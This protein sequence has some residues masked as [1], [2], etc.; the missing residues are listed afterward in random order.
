MKASQ[1]Y[2]GIPGAYLHFQSGARGIAVYPVQK[3]GT[4]SYVL[5]NTG[6]LA[7][8]KGARINGVGVP[9]FLTNSGFVLAEPGDENAA[10][11]ADMLDIREGLRQAES[12][13]SKKAAELQ[14]KLGGQVCTYVPFD[15]DKAVETVRVEQSKGYEVNT[16]VF[17]LD[18]GMSSG[19]VRMEFSLEGGLSRMDVDLSQG[20]LLGPQ[21][22]PETAPRGTEYGGTLEQ[23]VYFL[24]NCGIGTLEG[25]KNLVMDEDCSEDEV[26]ARGKLTLR[27]ANGD[28][29]LAGSCASDVLTVHY[30]RNE[31]VLYQRTGLNG[32]RLGDFVGAIM[33]AVVRVQ[34]LDAVPAKKLRKAA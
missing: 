21:E 34:E 33:A 23:A 28:M 10:K 27:L 6:K 15:A 3:G 29:L 12:A 31:K 4:E 13:S 26:F 20:W 25:P 11:L 19:A 22:D 2:V 16:Q 8:L 5:L 1:I 18:R 32:T 14:S 7:T 30:V 17:H 9:R 24:A